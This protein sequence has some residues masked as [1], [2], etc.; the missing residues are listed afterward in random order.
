MGTPPS[1]SYFV[2][3]STILLFMVKQVFQP[4]GL[5]YKVGTQCSVGQGTKSR[6]EFLC[7]NTFVLP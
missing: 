2:G 7:L 4:M 1:R 5:M 6:E 3:A